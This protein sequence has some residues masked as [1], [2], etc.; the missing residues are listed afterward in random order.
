[1]E[2]D[3]IR[4]I[5]SVIKL[6]EDNVCALCTRNHPYNRLAAIYDKLKKIDSIEYLS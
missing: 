4:D 6:Y 1:M 3:Q 5:N 2:I